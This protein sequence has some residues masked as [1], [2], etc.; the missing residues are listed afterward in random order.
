M[1]SLAGM[2]C[3][4]LVLASMVV[5]AAGEPFVG[6]EL[7]PLGADVAS[8][9]GIE[10]GVLVG[11]VMEK[12]PAATAGLKINDIIV[13]WNGKAVAAPEALV[14]EVKASAPGQEVKVKVLRKGVEHE[15]TCTIGT[16]EGEAVEAAPAPSSAGYLGIAFD[17][18]PEWLREYLGFEEAGQ[19]VYVVEVLEGSPAAKAGL[20]E[21]DIILKVN[22]NDVG[23]PAAFQTLMGG[24]HPNEA[25]AI[26][27][28]RAGRELKVEAS[29]AARPAN[30]EKKMRRMPPM[31]PPRPGAESSK[32]RFTLR[33]KDQSGKE[34]VIPFPGL[35]RGREFNF[36]MPKIDWPESLKG[37]QIQ[38]LEAR[39]KEAWKE[40][41]KQIEE[42]SKQ[43]KES[44]GAFM[45]HIEKLKGAPSTGQSVTVS[46][47]A[48]QV[49]S[50]DGT[51]EIS[52]KTEK[53]VKTV[54][55]KEGDKVLASDL[56]FEQIGTLPEAV[57]KKIKDLDATVIIKSDV[58]ASPAPGST[59]VEKNAEKTTKQQVDVHVPT[60]TL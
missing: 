10:A 11:G 25:F 27:G 56:P 49:M 50:C 20:K 42:H 6:M 30:F 8:Y 46:E 21:R 54:T 22:G 24:T 2:A 26:E 51:H 37:D 3:G 40:A 33:F 32:D 23:G 4:T 43:L 19:G 48:S 34:H 45:Q 18:V 31:M 9:L 44:H 60:R 28:L 52:I 36:E 16:R 39:V 14:A 7:R 1:K 5:C 59:P 57:Q 17:A 41:A 13:A 47:S 35:G 55:V 29:L 12:S 58:Q 15:L 38:D 53:G